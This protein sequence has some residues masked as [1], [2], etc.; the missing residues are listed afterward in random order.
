MLAHIRNGQIIQRYASERGWITLEDGSKASPPLAGYVNGNDRIVP[1]VEETIDNS[2]TPR[3]RRTTTEAVEADR[4]LRLTTVEDVPV[5][6]LRASARLDRFEFASRA[7][8]A[9]F[10]TYAEAAQWA[11]GNAVPTA[12]QAIIDA[13]PPEEQ[14]PATLDVLA[15]PVIRR[16]GD[17]MP[18]LAAAFNADDAGLDGLF[19]I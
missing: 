4:V 19:G 6:D 14:G 9:G 2:T 16:T 8:E 13:L 17:L 15:R 3:T 12:V 7:A 11:A 5:K 10:V 18:A 1:V